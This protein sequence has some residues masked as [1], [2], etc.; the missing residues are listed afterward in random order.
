MVMKGSNV[1]VFLLG[2]V[3]GGIIA[4]LYAPQSGKKTR[5][6][7]KDWVDDSLES[8][9]EFVDRKVAYAKDAVARGTQHVKDNMERARMYVDRKVAEAKE[10]LCDCS[11]TGKEQA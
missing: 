8:A 4:L 1:A 7:I 11:N 2:A 5:G 10:E 9:G 6:Q 3:A